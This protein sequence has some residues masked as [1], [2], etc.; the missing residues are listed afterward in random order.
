MNLKFANARERDAYRAGYVHGKKEG[1]Q[2]AVLLIHLMLSDCNSFKENILQNSEE[3]I[4]LR[5]NFTKEQKNE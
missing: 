2:K 5:K 1:L 3:A 4:E